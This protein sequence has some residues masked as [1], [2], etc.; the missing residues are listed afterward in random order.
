MFLSEDNYSLIW[1]Y[2]CKKYVHDTMPVIFS[3]LCRCIY[4]LYTLF[5]KQSSSSSWLY[6]KKILM[7]VLFLM[8]MMSLVN[9][10]SVSQSVSHHPC[11]DEVQNPL[12]TFTDSFFRLF[13]FDVLHSRVVENSNVCRKWQKYMQDIM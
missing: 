8:M 11:Y 10:K 4:E 2:V 5:F 1:Y 7:V 13:S 3:P 6:K 9:T 12:Q